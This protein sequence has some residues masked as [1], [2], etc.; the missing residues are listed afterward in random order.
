MS[1]KLC[2]CGG[3]ADLCRSR[4]C[5]RERLA[6]DVAEWAPSE[7]TK[8]HQQISMRKTADLRPHPK[9]AEI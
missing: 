1:K 4:K 7:E 8:V 6:A 3:P 2:P 9:N 5:I